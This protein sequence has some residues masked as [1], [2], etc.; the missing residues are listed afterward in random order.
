VQPS[1][2]RTIHFYD[3][4]Y[5]TTSREEK[6]RASSTLRTFLEFP[7]PGSNRHHWNPHITKLSIRLVALHTQPLYF[8]DSPMT[9]VEIK[10]TYSSGASIS[11]L[12]GIAY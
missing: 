10:K 5:T 11:H 9:M 1:I 2:E 7:N 8:S 6:S 12:Q 4:L 3:Q